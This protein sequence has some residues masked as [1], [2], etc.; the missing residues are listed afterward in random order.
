MRVLANTG[1][2]RER[3]AVIDQHPHASTPLP[4]LV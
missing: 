1:S 3:R 4:L 2:V